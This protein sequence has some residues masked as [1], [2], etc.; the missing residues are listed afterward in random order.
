MRR[1]ILA[2]TA[3]LPTVFS[4]G[5]PPAADAGGAGDFGE[6]PRRDFFPSFPWAR[7]CAF[8]LSH[9]PRLAGKPRPV[10]RT[11]LVAESRS[12]YHQG[13][14]LVADLRRRAITG[15]GRPSRV[16]GAWKNATPPSP[17]PTP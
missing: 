13:R 6:D 1:R 8:D 16:S 4:A 14:L 2:V 5:P 3:S 10:G 7:V 12:R 15:A 11:V 9:A 17:P